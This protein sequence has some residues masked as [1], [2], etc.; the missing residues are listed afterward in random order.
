MKMQLLSFNKAYEVA[1][2]FEPNVCEEHSIYGLSDDTIPWGEMIDVDFNT[3][4]DTYTF[5][6][7]FIPKYCFEE[8]SKEITKN[9]LRYGDFLKIDFHY[10]LDVTKIRPVIVRLISYKGD[11]FYYK[12]F[13]DTGE[14]I[15]C[16]KVGK[17]DES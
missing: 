7:F 17:T 5:D 6:D 13:D 15:E 4:N 8:N 2:I 12:T 9:I 14:V 10:E 1:K 11:I 3:K 16:E